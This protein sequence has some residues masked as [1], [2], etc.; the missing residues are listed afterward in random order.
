MTS[1]FN[2]LFNSL[3]SQSKSNTSAHIIQLNKNTIKKYIDGIL[4]IENKYFPPYFA[5]DEEDLIDESKSKGYIGYMLLDNDI[6]R[7]YCIGFT[8]T[9]D[10]YSEDDF[11]I[12]SFHHFDISDEAIAD[13]I[14]SLNLNDVFYISNVVIEN[15]S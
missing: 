1:K 14:G 5:Q 13:K 3:L 2:S 9:D 6:P 8:L 4:T 10:L 11:D 7:G 12:D 15:S